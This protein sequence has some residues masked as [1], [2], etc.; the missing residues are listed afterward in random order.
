MRAAYALVMAVILVSCGNEQPYKITGDQITE[1]LTSAPGDPVRGQAVF[2]EREQGHCVICHKV[3]GLD[4]SFQGNVGPDLSAVGDRFTS[5][6]LRLRIVD[7]SEVAP[8]T[9][10]PSYFRKDHLNQ[11]G[12]AYQDK[13][14]LTGQ[15][16]EDL[17]AYLATLETNR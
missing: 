11:V 17:V 10:M 12:Q 13:T 9:L 5:S 2:S 14:I 8:D 3:S 7:M 6:Q 1:A 4:V 15:Q 16:I